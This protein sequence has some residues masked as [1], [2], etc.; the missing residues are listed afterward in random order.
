M[1]KLLRKLFLYLFKEDFKRMKAL[2]RDLKGLIHRQKCAISLAEFVLNVSENSWGTS[3]FQLMFIIVQAHG[4][5]YLYRVGRRT[6]LN[7]LTSMKEVSGR[8]P[9]SYDSMTGRMS[10]LTPTPLI[11]KC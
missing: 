3:M 8:F 5:S 9:P 10:R 6:T 11:E 4:L 7:S 2:E 1:K